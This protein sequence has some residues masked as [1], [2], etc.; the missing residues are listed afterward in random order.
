MYIPM[1][2]LIILPNFMRHKNRI[3]KTHE[4]VEPHSIEFRGTMHD[5]EITE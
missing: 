5:V 4:Q 2:G 1:F 3:L